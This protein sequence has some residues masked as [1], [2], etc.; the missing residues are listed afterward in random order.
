MKEGIELEDSGIE[1]SKKEKIESRFYYEVPGIWNN[2]T[3]A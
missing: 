3:E 2:L 1:K